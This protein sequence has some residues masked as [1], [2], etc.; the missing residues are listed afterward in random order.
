MDD[1]ET[2]HHDARRPSRG[3]RSRRAQ[4]EQEEHDRRT[5][6]W[7]WRV[8]EA[9][10][11]RARRGGDGEDP[12]RRSAPGEEREGGEP[13]EEHARK[14]ELV[15]VGIGIATRGEQ[16]HRTGERADGERG[17]DQRCRLGR[18]IGLD[19]A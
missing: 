14:V 4:G 7:P 2:A 3:A 12:E 9:V 10:E 19:A 5:Q 15:R 13:G 11:R 16:G 1:E 8:A 18:L 6:R 17:V